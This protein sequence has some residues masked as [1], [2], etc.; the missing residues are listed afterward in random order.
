LK[1]ALTWLLR[2]RSFLFGLLPS[3]THSYKRSPALHLN[4]GYFFIHIF[5]LSIHIVCKFV[6]TNKS[7]SS[8]HIKSQ[9]LYSQSKYNPTFLWHQIMCLNSITQSWLFKMILTF[10]L[11]IFKAKFANINKGGDIWL[12]KLSSNQVRERII[13][14]EILGSH[15]SRAY[16]V[17]P[18]FLIIYFFLLR[19]R[20]AASNSAYY[21]YPVDLRYPSHR[22]HTVPV[23][24]PGFQ[25]MTIWLRVWHPNHSATALIYC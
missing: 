11:D 9:K 17:K 18:T 2:H 24:S 1:A 5:Y 12:V 7:H 20:G 25:P 15:C 6:I 19:L 8:N 21:G 23:P 10:K 14:R 13:L 3:K 22:Y 4:K 16:E